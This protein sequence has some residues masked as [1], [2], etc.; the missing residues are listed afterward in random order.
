MARHLCEQAWHE[1]NR[2]DSARSSAWQCAYANTGS[3]ATDCMPTVFLY[4]TAL[5]TQ[6]AHLLQS[7]RG[8][9]AS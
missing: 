5:R 2:H 1:V 6:S 9:T 8:D 4:T 7:P 3:S